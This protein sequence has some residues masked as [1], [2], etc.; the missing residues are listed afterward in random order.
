MGAIKIVK[1]YPEIFGKIGDTIE[2]EDAWRIIA[3]VQGRGSEVEKVSLLAYKKFNAVHNLFQLGLRDEAVN[4]AREALQFG[5]KYQVYAVA[6]QL[7]RFLVEDSLL[8]N[9][10]TTV[11]EY[12][13]LYRE[14]TEMIELEYQAK[15]IYGE[16]IYNQ[17]KGMKVNETDIIKC[18]G[19]I[20]EKLPFDSLTYHYYYHSC[21]I[22]LAVD[23]EYERQLL[24]AIHHFENFY[25]N[26]NSYLSS[27]V[28][29]LVIHYQK[30]EKYEEAEDLIT[31]QLKRCK[32]G[33]TVWFKYMKT[34]C[35]LYLSMGEMKKSKDC[36]ESVFKNN[37]F[38]GL[39]ERNKMEWSQFRSVII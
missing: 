18:L 33:C 30:E 4:L 29:K 8:G 3:S 15:L 36:I 31:S 14:Y 17:N 37:R 20:E 1:E 9:D 13:Q 11:L 5:V 39:P 27:F 6:Q 10:I 12:D 19:Q 35:I 38:Q 7:C 28:I 23:G 26:H 16:L 32:A 34:A 25:Y 24:V 21:I 2:E 22:L